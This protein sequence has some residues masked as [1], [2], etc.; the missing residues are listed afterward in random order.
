MEGRLRFFAKVLAMAVAT[1]ALVLALAAR[2]GP[3]PP[4]AGQAFDDAWRDTVRVISLRKPELEVAMASTA[5]KP[6]VTEKIIIAPDPTPAPEP[7]RPHAV[8]AQEMPREQD[9]CERHHMR[10][11][12]THGGRS[13]RCR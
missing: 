12:I 4:P 8:V 10:K 6:V 3:T 5:P 7:D 11:V 2:H 13:W 9:V 1:M